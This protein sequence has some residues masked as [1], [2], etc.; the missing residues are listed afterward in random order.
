MRQEEIATLMEEGHSRGRRAD[1]RG[2]E[3]VKS[4]TNNVRQLGHNINLLTA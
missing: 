3:T 4:T 1:N 2:T